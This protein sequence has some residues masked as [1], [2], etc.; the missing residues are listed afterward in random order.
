VGVRWHGSGAEQDDGA[1]QR[2]TVP[3]HNP[4]QCADWTSFSIRR[5]A[6]LHQEVGVWSAA[7]VFVCALR[8][9]GRS[10]AGF[11]LVEFIEHAPVGVS[12]VAEGYV[13][14]AEGRRMLDPF[15]LDMLQ[16]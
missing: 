11:P 12:P 2:V 1:Q 6:S 13:L 5:S 8:L 9:L 3:N 4:Q 15:R 14:S 16:V 10:E 7:T